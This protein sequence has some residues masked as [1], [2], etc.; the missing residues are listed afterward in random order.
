VLVLDSNAFTA[1][2]WGQQAFRAGCE[3]WANR[4]PDATFIQAGNEPD[5]GGAERSSSQT[6]DDFYR[7]IAA[8]R[9]AWPNATIVAGGLV[10]VDFTYLEGLGGAGADIAA[11]HP[12]AQTGDSVGALFAECRNHTDLALW[13]TEFGAPVGQFPDPHERAV[14]FTEMI[15]GLWRAGVEAAIVYR[16][17]AVDEE[18]F[19]I[20]GTESEA[21]FFDAQPAVDG[22]P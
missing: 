19:D 15:V 3:Y 5:Q 13:A 11:I 16:L 14:W 18:G 22:P 4:F 2:A 6:R 21:A 9:N 17:D 12:Y 8:A 20:A 10:H 1:Q 7:L